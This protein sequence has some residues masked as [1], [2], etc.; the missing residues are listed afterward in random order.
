MS[1]DDLRLLTTLPG[2]LG[3]GTP[4]SAYTNLLINTYGASEVWQLTNMSSTPILA[5][6][7]TARNG[8]AVGWELIAPN[9]VAGP[10][11]ADSGLAP[12]SDGVNDS[13]DVTTSGGGVGTV[14]IFDP[15]EGSFLIWTRFPSATELTDGV[16]YRAFSLETDTDNRIVL[17]K[18]VLN[19]W[20][21][22]HIAGATART[23]SVS[24]PTLG[25]HMLGFSWSA[26]DTKVF[27]HLDG[28]QNG[29]D[30]AAPGAWVG[31]LVR[32]VIGAE[33]T[34]PTTVFKGNLAYAAI[35]FGAYWTTA[36]FN[37]MYAA[38]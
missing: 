18:N 30:Q 7:N 17:G 14:D 13:G 9:A 29:S 27:A 4:F 31:A 6:V 11:A 10:S 8:V 15:A 22:A 20:T 21:F 37:A 23:V 1:L 12:Y 19:K 34:T 36:D 2:V 35:K 32:A 26:T 28:A 24:I 33:T 5:G 38:V 3:G 16:G 25:W